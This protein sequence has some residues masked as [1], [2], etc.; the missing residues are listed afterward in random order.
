MNLESKQKEPRMQRK[1][2]RSH[3]TLP[4]RLCGWGSWSTVCGGGLL[5]SRE[6]VGGQWVALSRQASETLS[7][8]A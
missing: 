1:A 6:K 4:S 5:S 3:L 7:L 8:T 2:V